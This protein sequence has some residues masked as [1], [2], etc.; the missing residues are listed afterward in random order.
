MAIHVMKHWM[1]AYQNHVTMVELV[2]LNHL[3]IHAIVPRVSVSNILSVTV[4]TFC[5][6]LN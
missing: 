4:L 3:D 5:D 1:I 2:S 6:I